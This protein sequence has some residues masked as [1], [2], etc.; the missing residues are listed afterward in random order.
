M[1][2]IFANPTRY[3]AA[4]GMVYAGCAAALAA[5]GALPWWTPPVAGVSTFTVIRAG[6]AAFDALVRRNQR[7]QR[8]REHRRTY[9]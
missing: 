4:S 1:R 6:I 3:S 2:W 5:V 8:E 9:G 7:I